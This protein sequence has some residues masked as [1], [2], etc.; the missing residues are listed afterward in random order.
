M[1]S[2]LT[3]ICDSNHSDSP[4]SLLYGPGVFDNLVELSEDS[5][6][7]TEIY[8]INKPYDGFEA[9][10]VTEPPCINFQKKGFLVLN[11]LLLGPTGANSATLGK[12][13]ALRPT[14]DFQTIP[15]DYGAASTRVEDLDWKLLLMNLQPL[16]PPLGTP[17]PFLGQ[18]WRTHSAPRQPHWS[19]LEVP[20]LV[21][22]KDG[23][24]GKLKRNLV[25]QDDIDTDAEGSDEIDGEELEITT[26]IQKKRI[27][28]TSLSP[29][30]ASTTINEVIRSPQP[31]QP[32]IRCPNRPS[33]L[34]SN[35]TNIQPPMAST[36]RDQISP[37]PESIFDHC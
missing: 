4:P 36:S 3:S 11:L 18:N 37:Q 35:S 22:R 10:R 32:P 21:T 7:P 19:N 1:S 20:I 12:E 16:I 30:Q 27:K 28:S 2:K 31:P 14:I 8:D 33:T 29:V 26:P 15:E 25:V 34:S 9:V 6:A 23:I 24:L 5:M 13:I 17:I